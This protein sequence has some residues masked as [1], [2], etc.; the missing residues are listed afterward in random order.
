[1]LTT[2]GSLGIAVGPRDGVT[3]ED[4]LTSASAAVYLA[5]QQG[6]N[7]A[8]FASSKLTEEARQQVTLLS[9]IRRGLEG[10]EFEPFYQPILDVHSGR[11][12]A[13]EALVRWRH[14]VRGL[15]FPADFIR[16]AEDSGLIGD[17]GMACMTRACA[18]SQELK[19]GG[20][21]LPLSVNLS[22]R[23]LDDE[24][25]VSVID[26][27]CA[28]HQVAPGDLSFEITESA[29]M[30]HPDRNLRILK[31]IRSLGHRLSVDDFGTGYSSLSYLERFPVDRIKIDRSFVLKV[32]SSKATRAIVTATVTLAENLGMDVVAEGVDSPDQ[33]RRLTDLGCHLQQ[34]F[35][36]AKALSPEDMTGW[37]ARPVRPPRGPRERGH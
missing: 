26:Q 32:E 1:V 11:T 24:R 8:Q 18:Y 22:A 3:P 19:H 25:I 37:L 10:G 14:P 28:R 30:Q 13:A 5:K 2:T 35:L 31:D 9:D 4:L 23:Q 16:T 6:R 12:V 29:V 20:R 36:F 21:R 17:L 33:M 15:V 27:L 34:G 7:N